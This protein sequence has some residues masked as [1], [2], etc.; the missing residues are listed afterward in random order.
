[1]D[2]RLVRESPAARGT[3]RIGK[4]W[5]RSCRGACQPRT[6]LVVTGSPPTDQFLDC[7]QEPDGLL[8]RSRRVRLFVEN[9][10]NLLDKLTPRLEWFNLRRRPRRNGL[11]KPN[12]IGSSFQQ[13]GHCDCD[14][15]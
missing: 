14:H 4:P 5:S 6:V 13:R 10:P 11:R 8:T 1:M 3:R 15:R 12:G 2:G 9:R 7:L